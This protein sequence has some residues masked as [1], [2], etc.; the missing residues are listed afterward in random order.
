MFLTPVICTVF[1]RM[2]PAYAYNSHT[3]IPGIKIEF[4]V[5][6]SVQP[7]P[8]HTLQAILPA[9]TT[10]MKEHVTQMLSQPQTAWGKGGRRSGIIII[11]IIIIIIVISYPAES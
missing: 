11:I 4:S 8:L 7:T 5:K 10:P 9:Q 3:P 2:Y 6:K 1:L